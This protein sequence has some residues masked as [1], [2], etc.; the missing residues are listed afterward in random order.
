[1]INFLQP[2]LA[3][4]TGQI[5]MLHMLERGTSPLEGCLRIP[6]FVLVIFCHFDMGINMTIGCGRFPQA[7]RFIKVAAFLLQ[8]GQALYC[9][10]KV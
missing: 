10:A 9:Q 7:D 4:I 6:A 1:M 2:I 5:G 8:N 3:H